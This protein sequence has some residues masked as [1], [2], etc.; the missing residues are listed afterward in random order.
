VATPSRFDDEL[1]RLAEPLV[2][3]ELDPV[4][5]DTAKRPL[6]RLARG[7][8]E[9]QGAVAAGR[10]LGPHIQ[11][12]PVLLDEPDRLGRRFHAHVTNGTTVRSRGLPTLVVAE[13]PKGDTHGN[14]SRGAAGLA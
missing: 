6:T 7:L 14:C 8:E 11:L 3:V 2:E 4:G 12:S 10:S 13:E 5:V 9:S 1:L